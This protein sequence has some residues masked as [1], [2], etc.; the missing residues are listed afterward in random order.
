MSTE[1]WLGIGHYLLGVLIIFA[2]LVALMEASRKYDRFRESSYLLQA[3]GYF[4]LLIWALLQTMSLGPSLLLMVSL[5]CQLAGFGALAIGYYLYF[6]GQTDEEVDAPIATSKGSVA[7]ISRRHQDVIG[8][9]TSD[10]VKSETKQKEDDVAVDA[11]A[12]KKVKTE[13]SEETSLAQSL[14]TAPIEAVPA[15]KSE[16]KKK[17]EL[18]VDDA[19]EIDLSYLSSRSRKSAVASKKTKKMKEPS[20]LE[21]SEPVETREELMD[22]LFPLKD[23]APMQKELSPVEIDTLPGEGKHDEIAAESTS[24]KKTK[25]EPKKMLPIG[26]LATSTLTF[27]WLTIWPEA[28]GLALLLILVLLLAPHR[29]S[30]GIIWLLSGFLLVAI[31]TGLA[32]AYTPQL[33]GPVLVTDGVVI[34][35]L[36]QQALAVLGYGLIG[37]AGWV[38]IKGKVTHHFLRI[39]SMVYLV[40]LFLTIGLA[41]LIVTDQE[42]LQ[43]LLVMM[44]GVLMTILPIIHSLTYSHPH[45]PIRERDD[46][47]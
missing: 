18:P 34:Q 7:R 8:M 46:R 5:G 4:L 1:L 44:T 3:I 33:D 6:H 10:E 26:I 41:M 11:I 43:L 17:A 29:R 19:N 14:P 40:L 36:A 42:S 22:E 38:K 23:A 39:V 45:Q 27:D 31:S 21:V 12:S 24:D 47:S 35:Y 15:K 30:R 2:L 37:I 28:A 32:A 16:K 9:L 25:L 20:V 13:K